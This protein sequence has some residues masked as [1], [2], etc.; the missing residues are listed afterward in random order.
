[1]FNEKELAKLYDEKINNSRDINNLLAR[2]DQLVFNHNGILM[3]EDNI[4]FP[5]TELELLDLL[6]TMEIN[7]AVYCIKFLGSPLPEH[8]VLDAGCGAGGTG[9]L[10]HKEYGCFI[11][12][13]TISPQQVQVALESA[14]FYGYS[15]KVNFF[16]GNILTLDRVDNYYN[17][18]YAS[19]NT[20]HLPNLDTMYKEFA[21][22]SRPLGRLVIVTWCATSTKFGAEIKHQVDNHYKTHIHTRD[23]YIQEAQ[24]C[25]WKLI[26]EIDLTTRTVPYWMLRSCSENR[27]GSEIFMGFGF[28]TGSLQ[29]YLF[30]FDL[31]D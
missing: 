23:E 31:V 14:A 4:S 19:E 28:A 27:T 24:K 26:Q 6:H 30:A 13:I 5:N 3:S 11:E 18:V 9:I 2:K 21:R 16:A 7:Q 12:G 20:E 25:G 22:V 1:M 10:I 29:Y 17:F 15:N 8:V